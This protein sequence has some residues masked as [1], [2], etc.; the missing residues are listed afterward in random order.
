MVAPRCQ[1]MPTTTLL[2]DLFA[3]RPGIG[4][5][6]LRSPGRCGR[7]AKKSTTF[8]SVRPA[9]ISIEGG[10][11]SGAG[12]SCLQFP[13]STN[14]ILSLNVF[15]FLASAF[16]ASAQTSDRQPPSIR[17]LGTLS[18]KT[19]YA[20]ATLT[21]TLDVDVG[22][23]PG[24]LQALVGYGHPGPNPV[25]ASYTVQDGLRVNVAAA[26]AV[27]TYRLEVIT[28]TA[29]S[30]PTTYRRNGDITYV[31]PLP[32]WPR[33]HSLDFSALDFY[34]VD[35]PQITTQP[36]SVRTMAGQ[37][38]AFTIAFHPNAPATVQWR[39][40]GVAIPGATR[41]RLVFDSVALSDAA[42]YD[43]VLSNAGVTATSQAATLSVDPGRI[44]N[45]SVREGVAENGTL[46]AG[47]VL[48]SAKAVLIRGVGRSLEQFGVPAGTTL[49]N[50]TID[51]VNS[52]GTVVAQND[53]A[54]TSSTL[55]AA[56]TRAGAF[57]LSSAQDSALVA[58]LPAGAYTVRL[59]DSSGRAGDSLIEVYD[60]D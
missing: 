29:S 33:T 31:N 45:I 8:I 19:A 46:T 9:T 25:Q 28:F 52:S 11:I 40:N 15:L 27:G 22:S 17:S 57:P 20:G 12:L 42:T 56:T 51:V 55:T 16:F 32:G 24:D 1:E 21:A 47:F 48:E 13:M 39:K 23:G 53:D 6:L 60:V 5:R 34:V 30:G 58:N 44:K 4:L 14:R 54:G 18:A 26:N 59:K 10:E 3:D 50:P 2:I 41:D 43:A 35:A 36:V 37:S 38:A 49:A 7:S